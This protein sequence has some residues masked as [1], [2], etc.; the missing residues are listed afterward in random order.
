MIL[1]SYACPEVSD[2]RCFPKRLRKTQLP[3]LR[4]AR[5]PSP[6]CTW[7]TRKPSCIM[8]SRIAHSSAEMAGNAF[9]EESDSDVQSRSSM[10][11]SSNFDSDS[12]SIASRKRRKFCLEPDEQDDV[13]LPSRTLVPSRVKVQAKETTINKNS[14][15]NT[16]LVPTYSQTTFQSLNVKPWLVGSL[17]SMAIK[18]PTGIQKGCIP[19]ILK[20]RDCIGGSRTGSG[21][22]VAFAVPI[23]QKWAEDPIG[24]FA[25][26]LTPTRYLVIQTIKLNCIN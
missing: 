11:V 25:V 15:N 20:G 4:I 6:Y 5:R 14:P 12:D 21:K 23:L 18:R 22:T 1:A 10:Q 13:P 19:E 2:W 16:V 7:I 8:V 3:L 26:I 9:N 24:I 17:S